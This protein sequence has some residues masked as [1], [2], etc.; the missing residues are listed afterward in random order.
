MVSWVIAVN[1]NI[2]SLVSR[3]HVKILVRMEGWRSMGKVLS[4]SKVV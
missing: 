1:L 4:L 2:A 3:D